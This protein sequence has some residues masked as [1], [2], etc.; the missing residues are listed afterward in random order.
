MKKL[1]SYIALF[2]PA[3]AFAQAQQSFTLKGKIDNAVPPAKVSLIYSLGANQVV[4]SAAISLGG[5]QLSGNTLFPVNATL[6][7][8]HKGVG[9]LKLDQTNADVLRF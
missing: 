6:V 4:D 8:D 3:V 7:L 5:F 9:L 1:I 2:I